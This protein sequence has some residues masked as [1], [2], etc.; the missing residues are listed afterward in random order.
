M[1]DILPL[2]GLFYNL[3]IYTDLSNMISPPYDIISPE[4]NK[5]LQNQ[6]PYNIV[7]LI[8]PQD[9]NKKNKYE[10][11]KDTL[12]N[13]INRNILKVNS[14]KCFYIIEERFTINN[15][16]R[17]IIGLI[18]LTRIEPYYTKKII[19]HE[20]TLSEPKQ[21]RLSLLRSCRTNFGLVYALYNDLQKELYSITNSE[22]YK[23][24][25]I[26]ITA[27]YDLT[28]KFKLW[29][30]SNINTINKVIKLMKGKNLLIADGHHRY[31]TSL[32]YKN[33]LSVSNSTDK[34][35]FRPEDYILTLY[36][37]SSQKD[38]SI[39]PTYRMIKFKS[40]PGLKEILEKIANYFYIEIPKIE[41]KNFFNDIN[42]KLQKS[43]LEGKKTFIIYS[44]EKKFCF[45]TLKFNTNTVYPVHNNINLE[46]EIL[47]VN[48]L[49]KFL[50]NKIKYEYGIE[51]IEFTHSIKEVKENINN[52]KFD[53]GII[54]NPPAITTLEKLST[55]GILMPQKTTY[56]YP[57]PCTGL[58]MY[59]F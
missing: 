22:I 57:K 59:K 54:L 48:I 23:K 41:S 4:M 44:K 26:D 5:K 19:R 50:L 47:D 24:P 7:N 53:I 3:D 14:K 35:S 27:G 34:N 25:F 29:R 15:K 2:N 16:K 52:S 36:V 10:V 56:F 28:L 6:N 33:E 13:W 43:K 31:E 9:N 1:V 17:K 49:H 21:D 40:C 39:L 42:E 32:M 20:K 37:D 11:A 46:Y 30:I 8:L 18:G 51:K 55:A 12:Q 38:I 58:V 45:L